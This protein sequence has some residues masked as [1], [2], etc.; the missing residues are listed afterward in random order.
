MFTVYYDHSLLFPM[1][2]RKCSVSDSFATQSLPVKTMTQK[3]L[4]ISSLERALFRLEEGWERYQRDISDAQIRD[5][6]IQRFEFT[7]EIS[8]EMLKRFLERLS[9]NP[10]IYHSMSLADLIRSGNEHALLLGTWSDWKTYRDM[11][12][13]T[14]HSYNED[15]AR[16]VVDGIVPFITEARYLLTQLK[17]RQQ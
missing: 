10:A 6:L 11:C 5:G 15:I 9:P 17:T 14:S 4:D 12:A 3:A 2:C 16:E 1:I 7:Y 13:R 8:H